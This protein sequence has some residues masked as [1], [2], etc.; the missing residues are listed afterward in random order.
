MVIFSQLLESFKLG[1]ESAMVSRLRADENLH[2]ISDKI[3]RTIIS[4]I[5]IKKSYPA[6]E[7]VWELIIRKAEAW[8][9]NVAPILLELERICSCNWIGREIQE[10]ESLKVEEDWFWEAPRFHSIPSTEPC[11][12]DTDLSASF[13]G[14]NSSLPSRPLYRREENSRRSLRGPTSAD[15]I[16]SEPDWPPRPRQIDVEDPVVILS[17]DMT[18]RTRFEVAVPEARGD[19]DDITNGLTSQQLSEYRL[20]RQ[21]ENLFAPRQGNDHAF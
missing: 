5:Y 13:P 18:S 12:Y 1:M 17:Q 6:F 15:D 7:G 4:M 14:Y 19:Y 8:V 10:D 9:D 11:P 20:A 3:S 2:Q 21:S 16:D